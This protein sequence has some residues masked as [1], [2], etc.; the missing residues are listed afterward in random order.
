[1]KLK[2][3][4]AMTS[5]IVMTAGM[6][7]SCG[8]TSSSST[9]DSTADTTAET[10][11]VAETTTEAETTTTAAETSAADS[12]ASKADSTAASTSDYKPM[13]TFKGYDAFLMFVD[14]DWMWKNME[15]QSKVDGDGC[16]GVDADITKDG[17]YTVSVTKDSVTYDDPDQGKNEQICASDGS[18]DVTADNIQP[19]S[20]T[21]VFCVDIKGILKGKK[22]KGTKD[23]KTDPKTPGKYDEKDLK[24]VLKSIKADG[25]EVKFDATKI[26]YGNIEN[27]NN[28][29]RIEIANEYGKTK[30]DPAIDKNALKFSE[31]LEVTFTIKGL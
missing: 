13:R 10:T 27:N 26:K 1:M 6:L 17:E 15:G 9:A 2:R 4:L 14:K 7:A 18:K 3:I 21:V 23:P 20:G 24:V 31:K 12:A 25:K 8:S 22:L 16:Y 28:K 5:A 11:T 30:K 29:Y 19:A